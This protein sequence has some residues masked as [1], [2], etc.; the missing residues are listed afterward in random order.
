V[1]VCYSV[2]WYCEDFIWWYVTVCS[3]IVRISS[4]GMLHCEVGL[5][6]VVEWHVTLHSGTMRSVV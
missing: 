5:N 4:G 6:T 2:Q 3:G 1:V